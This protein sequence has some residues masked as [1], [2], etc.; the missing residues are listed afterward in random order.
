M[1]NVVWICTFVVR[2]SVGLLQFFR[3]YEA[4]K[5]LRATSVKPGLLISEEVHASGKREVGFGTGAG[6]V[7]RS[8]HPDPGPCLKFSFPIAPCCDQWEVRGH[9]EDAGWLLSSAPR[10]GSRLWASLPCLLKKKKKRPTAQPLHEL[11]VQKNQNGLWKVPS[12]VTV[13]ARLV[14]KVSDAY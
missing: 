8:P 9:E 5:T 6:P 4:E 11:I 7:P 3:V 1:G 14:I 2:E 13:H 12:P 10:P